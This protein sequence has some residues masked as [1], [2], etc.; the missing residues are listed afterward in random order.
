MY[1][2][3]YNLM[4]EIEGLNGTNMSPIMD[5]QQIAARGDCDWLVGY[6]EFLRDWWGGGGHMDE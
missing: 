2:G 4:Q 5:V 3:L 6:C 1:T